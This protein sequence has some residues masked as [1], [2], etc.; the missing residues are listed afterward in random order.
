MP[1][2][3]RTAE[4]GVSNSSNEVP[5]GRPEL[6]S[7]ATQPAPVKRQRVSRACDQ[8]RAAR[9]R[10]D[11]KQPECY[12]CISQSRPCTYQVSPKKRGVQTG[13]IRT[14]ELALGWVLEKVP[15]SEDALGALLAYESGQG[16]PILTGKDPGRVDSLQKRWR[17]SRVHRRIDRILAGGTVGPPGPEGASASV[18]ASDT[19]RGAA[20]ACV[21]TC[22][23]D[24]GEEADP[25][26]LPDSRRGTTGYRPSNALDDDPAGHEWQRG[27]PVVLIPGRPPPRPDYLKLP[28]NHWRLLDIYFSYTHSWLP[29]LEKQDL[30]Q[31]S[32]LYPEPGRVANP[33]DI[34]SPVHAE[35]WAALALASLQDD[36][37]SLNDT[38]PAMSPSEIYQ[39]A[40]GFVPTEGGPFSVQHVRALLLLS[41]V[42]LGRDKLAA[43][44]LLTGSAIRILHDVDSNRRGAH[45]QDRERTNLIWMACF[46]L[47]TVLSVRCNKPPHLRIEDLAGL[48]LVSESGP[49]QWE[50]W[51]P[52]DGFGSSCTGSRSSRSPA[53][54]LST[55]NQ[56]YAIMKVVAVG[57]LARTTGL[58]RQETSEAFMTQ[59]HQAID[60]NFPFTSFV[61]SPCC[62]TASVPTPYVA[63]ATY[64]W[65]NA[66]ADPHSEAFL[67]TL[68]DTLHR[69]QQ[70]FGKCGMP[71]ILS[72][73]IGSLVD[74]QH[75]LGRSERDEESLR[76]FVSGYT[77]RG[78]EA[79]HSSILGSHPGAL[80]QKTRE[81]ELSDM[82]ASP[83]FTSPSNSYAALVMP[84]LSDG[85]STAR[86]IRRH[87]SGGGYTAFAGP[88]MAGSY[89][90]PFHNHSMTVSPQQGR[91]THMHLGTDVA[92]AP[93]ITT[94]VASTL[95]AQDPLGPHTGFG[96]GPDYDALL[97]DLAAIECTDAVDMDPQFMANL[98]FAPGCDIT[99]I[100]TRSFGP[101]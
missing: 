99:D 89:Q 31:A 72:A 85:A 75:L 71:P 21:S 58:S 18:D 77:T 59:L 37:S 54:C 80:P 60:S 49:D 47:E 51:T 14:L 95:T 27:T 45:T 42:N 38:G 81:D 3:R 6:A 94:S 16:H 67:P 44:G 32:Y 36:A 11:G 63:R 100:L 97:D 8:C 74:Q 90:G 2:K 15:G 34:S 46:V 40:R 73:Y 4:S 82:T 55:F 76:H 22:S 101:V 26:R 83:K 13:Y 56:I 20:R 39:I 64:L 88:S 53:F 25:Q 7:P 61:I 29:I 69:Y 98:G 65:A 19:E 66:L 12:P 50:P 70:R 78:S 10:C 92:S 86:R 5:V 57:T 87:P 17:E 96:V 24:G 93:G 33:D 30:F 62:G 79:R 84:S 35:L 91:S 28:P 41:L 1:P 9:E 23:A 52:C 68:Q 48:P 43:A